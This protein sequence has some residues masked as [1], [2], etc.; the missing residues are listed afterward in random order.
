MS[1]LVSFVKLSGDISLLST[2]PTKRE[3]KSRIRSRNHTRI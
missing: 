3:L 1:K 2:S